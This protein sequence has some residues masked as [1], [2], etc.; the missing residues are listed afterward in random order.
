MIMDSGQMTVRRLKMKAVLIAVK[1]HLST[2]IH[3]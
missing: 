3:P 1:Y 2:I